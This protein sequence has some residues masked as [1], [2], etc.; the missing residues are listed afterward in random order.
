MKIERD[1][2]LKLENLAKLQLSE[3][4]Q[5]SIGNDLEYIL[6]MIE[7]LNELDLREVEPLSYISEGNPKLRTDEIQHQVS[8]EAALLNAPNKTEAY[9]KVPKVI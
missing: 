3:D 5:E 2:I 7:K 9:F 8:R 4:E 1:L 6:S